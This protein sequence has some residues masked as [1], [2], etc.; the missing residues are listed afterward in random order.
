MGWLSFSKLKRSVRRGGAWVPLGFEQLE[1]REMPDSSG[2]LGKLLVQLKPGSAVPA[3]FWGLPSGTV[4]PTS[5]PNWYQVRG[6]SADIATLTTRLKLDPTV[7]KTD[8]S[9]SIAIDLVPNDPSYGSL[10]GLN[11][12]YGINAP[13]AWNNSVGTTK[14]SVAVI[15]TGIDVTHND[16]YRNIWINQ[17]EIPANIKANIMANP[18][19]DVDGDGLITF[20]DLND[21][22]N[23]GPGKITDIDGDGKITALDILKTTAQGGWAN[24]VSDDGD[25]THV[26][27]LVGWNFVANNN[28]PL[29]DNSHGTHV[30][31]TIGATGNDGVGVVG[32]NWRT[33]LMA[34]KILD[35]GGQGYE[36]DGAL[37]IAYAA[38]HGAKVSNN[39][40]SGPSYS[41][42]LYDAITYAGT[43]NELVVV[44]AGNSSANTDVAPAYP[45]SYPH[46]NLVSVA[47]ITIGGVRAGFSNY[48]ATTVDIGAP[49]AGVLST[50]PNNGY[51]SY[52]GTSMATPHVAGAAAWTLGLFPFLSATQVKDLILTRAT[53]NASMAGVSVS[54]GILNLNN[55]YAAG[56]SV[57]LND[58]GTTLLNNIA[59][60]DL[61]VNYLGITPAKVL[62][63]ANVGTQ[64]LT[65]GAISVPTGYVVSAPLASTTLIP[66]QS[67]TF[68][69]S[70][71]GLAH[72][73]FTGKLS[74][75][76]NDPFKNPF[77]IN[78]TGVVGNRA[79][80][81]SAIVDQSIPVTQASLTLPL[82]ATDADND[83]ITLSATVLTQL[84][85]LKQ[86][87]GLFAQAS[88][89]T[90]FW[91]RQ[92]KWLYGPNG[93]AFFILPT[94]DFYQ[95]TSGG[96]NGNLLTTLDPSVYADPT[97][98]TNP[99][100]PGSVAS[101]S[102]VGTQLTVTHVPNFAGKLYITVAANDGFT[103]TS[104]SFALTVV[105]QAPTIA[106]IADQSSN[107]HVI[108]V[109]VVASDP[110]GQ[111]L[112]LTATAL[113]QLAYLRQTYGLFAQ[114][115]YYT[116][117]YGR[118]EK[119]LYG[120]NGTAFFI[121]PTGAFL[122]WTSGGAN[123]N[124]LTTLDPS[125]Y[126]DPTK[127]TAANS[128]GVTIG[129]VGSQ[130]VVTA[131]PSVL[132]QILVTASVTDGI[133]VVSRSFTVTVAN[134]PP[135]VTAPANQTMS[136]A[137]DFITLPFTA[138]DADGQSLTVTATVVSQ[139]ASLQ[140]TYGLFAQANYY[141]N[142][143]GRQE[144]WLY[145]PNGT[146]FFIL[147]TGDFYQWTSG[148][149]NGNLVATVDPS[150]YA[151]PTKLTNPLLN[152][153]TATIVGS[154]IVVDPQ[155][156]FLGKLIV[157]ISASD[158]LAVDSKSFTVSV[159]NQPPVL[160][161]IADQSMSVAQGTLAVSFTASD[162][163]GQT[164][165]AT[166]TALPQLAYLK[167]TYGL[168]AQ[169]SYYT[170][171]YGRQEKWLYGP[172]GAAF[173]ILPNGDLYQ[174]SGGAGAVG[175]VIANIDPSAYAD[176]TKLTNA[177]TGGVAV[178]VVGGQVIVA[179]AANFVGKIFVTL[180]V[181]D[182]IAATS[183][184]FNVN[185][186]NAPPVV[187]AL[188]NQTMT[189][190]QGSITVPFSATDADG[191][192]LAITAS[193]QSQ[194]AFLKQTY[195]L[196]AQ[197]SY[198]TNYYGRQ[199]KWLYG[200]GGA[201]FFILPNG[202]LYQWTGG[203]GAVG[204][205]VASTSSAA[206]QDPTLLTNA[207]AGGGTATIVGN[208]LTVTPS[209]GFL[210]VLYVTLSAYDGFATTTRTF[211]VTVS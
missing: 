194:N 117:Y 104:K 144:K 206:Y 10:W 128:A 32:V 176:P 29:D 34:L 108:T 129:I 199:E 203:A 57:L 30:S 174:W 13:A 130:I 153:A 116:N 178:S 210:G 191:Q 62:T 147:P 125:V 94:G 24:G 118:Q 120:P 180:S 135:V 66:G 109:P 184:S 15:D 155:A 70:M 113:P 179:P 5:I 83:P 175:N 12:T 201:A 140:Q 169:A 23:Q 35:A 31:G 87:Y 166:A 123:G 65:L 103:S 141:T 167:Q 150:A 72:G 208:Q 6:N 112:T 89:Y 168:Y 60:V 110:D 59:T 139:L 48:G 95:W 93:T 39:S 148:G 26:D 73:T 33:Q 177:S 152:V 37:A 47:A 136:A 192:T 85:Y 8:A 46:N 75:A 181:S 138:T 49:G 195:G 105:N 146:A 81:L 156:G 102:F 40:W 50:V 132:G 211:T 133:A 134:S 121:L 55:I 127:L 97:L 7:A 76:S 159:L 44:A 185:V 82:S 162:P 78:L 187:A 119:W 86:T 183:Q 173:F 196:F 69:I 71:T 53:P 101:T 43:K 79:P 193:V 98:L 126:A 54:G 61:G 154:N 4:T 131:A 124:L 11:G 51:A 186:V 164:L 1:Q 161:A 188:Q 158:G 200:P 202:D 170:N 100:S 151:D 21:P 189:A 114:A 96:A 74:L 80:V 182:G 63:V 197:A 2:T 25:A 42:S 28:M 145:G 172:G 91:G 84:G 137:V 18:N 143:Y 14:V 19:W 90:N 3:N 142:F 99:A 77:Y 115:S 107:Q 9:R 207:A 204:N 111:T 165:T 122:Q 88:Y 205:L 56:P 52:S 41:Q 16:L 17:A 198:Y 38:N 157:T 190:A 27:D 22:R 106:F 163:D 20:W 92:E 58:G 67:T 45:A 36:S 64:N 68:S 160:A 171:F 149:A 209:N